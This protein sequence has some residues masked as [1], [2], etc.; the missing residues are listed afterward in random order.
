MTDTPFQTILDPARPLAIIELSR[1]DVGNTLT[2]AEVRALGASI[3]AEGNRPQVKAVMVRS[4][5]DAFCLGRAHAS[6]GPAA[7]SPSAL[8]IRET[9]AEPI[10]SLYAD[11][12]ATEVPVIAVVQGEARGFGCALVGQC[13]LAIAAD[14]ALFSLPEMDANLPPTLAI[15]ALLGKVPPKR[16]LDMVLTRR[17][18]GAAQALEMG[19]LSEIHPR[20]SLT[21]AADETIARLID[22]SRPALCAVKE[23]LL[24]AQRLDPAAA[25]RLAANTI[26]T[27][28]SSPAA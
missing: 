5:G 21:D 1:P 11:I 13:D 23:Y 24:T 26:A 2:A 4:R 22:R 28:F 9:L 15:S 10:L 8:Q 6:P 18:I 16:L 7:P 3:K 27:V 20:E 14:T 17:R 25:A 12:R 19:I